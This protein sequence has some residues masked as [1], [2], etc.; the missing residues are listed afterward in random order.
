MRYEAVELATPRELDSPTMRRTLNS[1]LLVALSLT[2]HLAG[3]SPASAESLI[4]AARA[5]F[6]RAIVA[7]DTVA[8]TSFFA[9]DYHSVSSRNTQSNGRDAERASWVSMFATRPGLLFVRTPRTIA[10][11]S[12]W[13]QAGESGRWCD[14]PP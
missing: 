1:A 2:R 9:S 12:R 11:N 4:R 13:G 14:V 7:H 6:N 3:Q 8:I 10:V 5:G